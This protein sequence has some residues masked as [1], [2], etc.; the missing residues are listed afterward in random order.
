MILKAR[1]QTPGTPSARP[2]PQKNGQHIYSVG[3]EH[4]ESY[5]AELIS[6]TG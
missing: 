2:T 1:E 5:W 4:S 6:M 3:R